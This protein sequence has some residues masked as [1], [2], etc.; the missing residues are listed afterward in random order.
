MRA[1]AKAL[2]VVVAEDAVDESEKA[3][4]TLSS[5]KWPEESI[6]QPSEKQE[7]RMKPLPSLQ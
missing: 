4:K 7:A 6:D 5:S 2:D 3:V 1:P